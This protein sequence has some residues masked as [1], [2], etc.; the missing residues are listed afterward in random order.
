[1]KKITKRIV[2]I[3]TIMLIFPQIVC[4]FS[5]REVGKNVLMTTGFEAATGEHDTT[6]DYLKAGASIGKDVLLETA[7]P[8]LAVNM[9]SAAGATASTG[10]AISS[11]SG[12]AA[13]SATMAWIGG[14]AA[15]LL[16]AVGLTVAPAVVGGVIVAGGA[17]CLGMAIDAIM[18][19][20]DS[21]DQQ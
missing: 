18:F 6:A 13:T 9:A 19:S 1:M 7:A 14:P 21:E 16:G 20:D 10:T 2:A 12:A 5:V 4:A 8:G 3:T 15:A 17:L 11:L